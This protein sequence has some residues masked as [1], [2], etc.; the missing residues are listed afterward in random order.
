MSDITLPRRT[1]DDAPPPRAN[2]R[3]LLGAAL[4][5][6]GAATLVPGASARTTVVQGVTGATG[7]TGPTGPR[8]ATGATGA[9]GA[10]G[11]AGSAGATGAT[12]TSVPA[13]TYVTTGPLLTNVAEFGTTLQ[14][15]EGSVAVSAWHSRLPP[16]WGCVR[17]LPFHD[18]AHR[19]WEVTFVGPAEVTVIPWPLQIGVMCVP[20]TIEHPASPG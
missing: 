19:I 6:A 17:S 13:I 5:A 11:P 4:G 3:A 12:G 20:G 9:T 15:P 1:D 8:G 10:S 14:C 2:R 18:A 16:G 7:A